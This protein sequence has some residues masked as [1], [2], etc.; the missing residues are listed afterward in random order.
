MYVFPY[1]RKL[2]LMNEIDSVCSDSP[3]IT[4]CC[5]LGWLTPSWPLIKLQ[6]RIPQSWIPPTCP[7]APEVCGGLFSLFMPCKLPGELHLL[8]HHGTGRPATI[9]SST[10]GIS[11]VVHALL[12]TLQQ[13]SHHSP[14]PVLQGATQILALD[15]NIPYPIMP[16]CLHLIIFPKDQLLKPTVKAGESKVSLESLFRVS[17]ALDRD[18]TL[19]SSQAGKAEQ[20]SN[21]W[22]FSTPPNYAA[23]QQKCSKG[24]YKCKIWWW[25]TL[26]HFSYLS[27]HHF[28]ISERYMLGF[29]I[30]KLISIRNI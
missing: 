9:I 28:L 3:S 7:S 5:R 12:L 30:S 13:T 2:P 16:L 20:R 14:R 26:E 10:M 15:H 19:C 24:L 8:W 29:T 18:W 6:W 11:T 23:V 25:W 17:R 21:S 4:V 1:G 27:L 22:S